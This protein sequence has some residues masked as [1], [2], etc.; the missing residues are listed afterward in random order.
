MSDE[1]SRRP[2]SAGTARP[3]RSVGP[4][5]TVRRYLAHLG[6]IVIFLAAGYYFTDMFLRMLDRRDVVKQDNVVANIEDLQKF[7]AADQSDE[8]L[9]AQRELVVYPLGAESMVRAT[10]KVLSDIQEDEI[11]LALKTVFSETSEGW[12]NQIVPKHVYRDGVT[13]YI[14]LPGSFSQGLANMSEQRALL[15]MT[16]LVRTIVENF[17]PVKQVYFLQDGRWVTNAGKIRLS[18]PWGFNEKG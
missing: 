3:R 14:D 17:P 5:S 9:A 13:A 16:G 6:V 11:V 10:L 1:I 18:E 8:G 12:A 7:L 4:H 2:V 15:M